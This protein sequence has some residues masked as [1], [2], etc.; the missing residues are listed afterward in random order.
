MTRG[1]Y[2]F[3]F[4]Y[5]P[6]K[7]GT[8]TPSTVKIAGKTVFLEW[9]KPPQGSDPQWKEYQIYLLVENDKTEQIEI[10]SEIPPHY[11]GPSFQIDDVSLDDF[12]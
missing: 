11:H 10:F 3:S 5:K 6:S 1:I 7:G 12:R 4:W 8:Q 9:V 2:S